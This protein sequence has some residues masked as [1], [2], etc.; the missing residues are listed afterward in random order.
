MGIS[1]PNNWGIFGGLLPPNVP[2]WSGVEV[3]GFELTA[4]SERLLKC[5]KWL[6]PPTASIEEVLHAALS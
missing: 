5:P 2:A 1:Q 6:L 4:H 3:L